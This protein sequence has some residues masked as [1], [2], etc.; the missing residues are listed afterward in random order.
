MER[1]STM[2]L[3]MLKNKQSRWVTKQEARALQLRNEVLYVLTE[4]NESPDVP[5]VIGPIP[6]SLPALA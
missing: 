4:E 3:V 5:L 6:D 1:R 2:Y